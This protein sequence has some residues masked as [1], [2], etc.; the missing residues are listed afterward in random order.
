MDVYRLQWWGGGV[1]TRKMNDF[2]YND[3]IFHIFQVGS[4]HHISGI[5]LLT[6][7]RAPNC[8]MLRWKHPRRTER[9]SRTEE[10]RKSS[11]ETNIKLHIKR[12]RCRW[13]EK[14]FLIF[15]CY[16]FSGILWFHNGVI[17]GDLFVQ[18][19]VFHVL[20]VAIYDKRERQ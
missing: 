15:C 10:R 11:N 2:T 19:E 13:H 1:Q 7:M 12:H 3:G 9:K 16:F 5:M 18:K 8:V 20:K 4:S 17:W 14:D 6:D